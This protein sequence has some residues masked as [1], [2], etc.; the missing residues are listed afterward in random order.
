MTTSAS[1]SHTPTMLQQ[2]GASEESIA[3]ATL[4]DGSVSMATSIAASLQGAGGGNPATPSSVNP[5]REPTPIQR[6]SP[7]PCQTSPHRILSNG[8]MIETKPE[9][10]TNNNDITP[11]A[12]P[13]SAV[14]NFYLIVNRLTYIPLCFHMLISYLIN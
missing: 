3:M 14:K 1:S 8:N 12:S 10:M 7:V 11:I 6:V 2:M 4:D 13:E 5:S 9:L